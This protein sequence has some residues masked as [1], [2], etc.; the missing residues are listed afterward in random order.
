MLDARTTVSYNG[1]GSQLQAAFGYR[2]PTI[3]CGDG[4]EF[5]SG[6]EATMRWAIWTLVLTSTSM[7]QHTTLED[8]RG[9]LA[10]LVYI[11]PS[12]GSDW[13]SRETCLI[14]GFEGHVPE[15]LRL[16]ATGSIS[17]AIRLIR[18]FPEDET[19]VVY[20]PEAPLEPGEM[21]TVTAGTPSSGPFEWTFTA[22]PFDPLV[23]S[24]ARPGGWP[25]D[26]APDPLPLPPSPPQADSGSREVALPSDFPVLVFTQLGTQAPGNLFFAPIYPT[27]GNPSSYMVITDGI[28][29]I[30]FYR[31]A[32][33]GIFNVEVQPDGCLSFSSGSAAGGDV[34]WLELD[35]TYT[36][37]DSFSVIGYPTDIHD[38]TAAQNGNVLLIGE[39]WRQIDLSG[40]VPGGQPDA[41]VLGLLIQEQDRNHVPVFQWSSFDHF[42]ITDACSFVD[43]TAD[44]VDYV[45][46][47]SLDEDADGD[48]LVSCLSMCECTR[49]DRQTGDL[50]WRF[51]GYM[52]E[53]PD[54]TIVNDPLGGFSTQHDFRHSTGNR[55][56]VFDNGRFHSTQAS[57]GLEYE[58]D[59]QEMTATLVWSYQVP[60]L[61]ASHLGSTLRLPNGGHVIGWG[62]VQGTSTRP[63]IT[64]L[65]PGGSPVLRV[66][67]Q[68]INL[69]SYRAYKFDWIG[70][71]LRPYLVAEII[72]GETCVTLTY[73]VFSDVEY[74]T[75]DIYTGTSPQ[76]LS[77]L[78]STSQKQIKVWQLPPGWNYFAVT[79]RDAQGVETGYSNLDSALVTWTG[80]SQGTAP[81]AP[82]RLS[83][84]PCPAGEAATICISSPEETAFRIRVFDGAGRMVMPQ[85]IL[86]CLPG[87]NELALPVGGLP[88]GIYLVEAKSCSDRA[89]ARLVVLR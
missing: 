49:I 11:C 45:H 56:T 85:G 37:V 14:L 16:E 82:L 75:Y 50:V 15:G 1:Y 79:A 22:R 86:N 25:T 31:H 58:L 57:R 4:S 35:D 52:S 78:T 3:I 27:G 9:E 55:Y 47:N 28:G 64:E 54:F 32:H 26:E 30:L 33:T 83:V 34:S 77:F 63:D 66:R 62:D 70:Q 51:G 38:F 59:L 18:Y 12:A 44:Y 72:A 8:A 89:V 80:I 36:T 10:D 71:A 6:R 61:Y 23:E 40:I 39:D 53:N 42:E 29:Q 88:A 76:N 24:D 74:P 13:Q 19:R 67:F 48:L 17:G 21:I 43:L 84:S 5:L 65:G 87:D 46:C 2:P 69:E 7:G 41:M 73:N 68:P 81:I 60:G 20:L